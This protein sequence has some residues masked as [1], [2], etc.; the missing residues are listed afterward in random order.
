MGKYVKSLSHWFLLSYAALIVSG[1]EAC[2]G[3]GT[4]LHSNCSA[5]KRPRSVGDV[6]CGSPFEA[7]M[8]PLP[9]S[10]SLGDP[11]GRV[12]R[13]KVRASGALAASGRRN[14]DA[15]EQERRH[16]GAADALVAAPPTRTAP[17]ASANNAAIAARYACRR[18]RGKAFTGCLQPWASMP[19]NPMSCGAPG[20]CRC[21]GHCIVIWTALTELTMP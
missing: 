5:T 14:V 19:G 17:A 15:V 18:G 1:F 10:P 11:A 8:A 20:P 16:G 2:G 12:A 3:G 9:R 21:H 13:R 7:R 6:R 4:V